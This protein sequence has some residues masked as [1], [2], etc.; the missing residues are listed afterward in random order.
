MLQ[1][2]TTKSLSILKKPCQ[3]SGNAALI[4]IHLGVIIV[5]DRTTVTLCRH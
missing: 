1:K 4:I 5:A 3:V 2:L